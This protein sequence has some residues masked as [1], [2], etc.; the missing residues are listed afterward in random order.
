MRHRVREGVQFRIPG[1]QFG[2]LL[3]Q[4]FFGL[5]VLVEIIEAADERRYPVKRHALD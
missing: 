1:E 2:G 4:R 5:L 3:A